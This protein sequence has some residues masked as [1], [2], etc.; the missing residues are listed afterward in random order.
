RGREGEGDRQADQGFQA[1]GA[2][3]DPGRQRA[4]LRQVARRF[5]AGHPDGPRQAGRA[6]RRH[7]VRK[8]P[9]LTVYAARSPDWIR[10]AALRTVDEIRAFVATGLSFLLA[11]G[12][13]ARD[14][15]DGRSSAP[16]PFAIL[17]TGAGTLATARVLI[18]AIAGPGA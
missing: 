14:W 4:R 7:A 2:G 17:A 18:S 6:G 8:F 9:R 1:Q 15:A 11:P 3:G 16:N 12:A 5:A 13:F 10:D